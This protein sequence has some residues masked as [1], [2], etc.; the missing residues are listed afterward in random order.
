MIKYNPKL[1]KLA[2]HFRKNQTKAESILWQKLRRKQILNVQFYRQRPV[3]DYIVDFCCFKPI[4]LIIE[5]DG[6]SHYKKEANKKDKIREA[7]LKEMG[8]KILR[9]TNGDI[10][11][12]LEGV[13]E[14]IYDIIKSPLTPL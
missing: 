12:N 14:K 8:F 4:K 11:E 9:F 5:I 1:K 6:D 2:R 3:G 7:K 13:L 10:Y